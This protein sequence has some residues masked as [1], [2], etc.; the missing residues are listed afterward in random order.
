MNQSLIGAIGSIFTLSYLFYYNWKRSVLPKP[1]L[2]T[3]FIV[4]FYIIF[5]N[6]AFKYKSPFLIGGVLGLFFSIIGRFVLDLP[7]KL[8][9]I[10]NEWI[11]HPGA[12]IIY[13]IYFRYFLHP[14]NKKFI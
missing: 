3:F 6:I 8:F 11:V 7:R 1:F 9:M 2:L 14:L 12:F 13:G 4:L 10:K 5:N